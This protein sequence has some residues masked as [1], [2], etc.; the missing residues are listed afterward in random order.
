MKTLQSCLFFFLT[1]AASATFALDGWRISNK[2]NLRVYLPTDL[3]KEQIFMYV[4]SGPYDLN[5]AT[6]KGWFSRKAR[7]MQNRLGKPLKAWVV[8]PDKGNWS[9]SNQYQDK[10]G[11]Q[12]S[13]G[14]Q[15][16][17]LGNGR[18]YIITMISSRDYVLIM[19]YGA[20]YEQVLND[21]KLYLAVKPSLSKISATAAKTEKIT[22]TNRKTTTKKGKKISDMVRTAPGK[23]A[24]LDDIELVWVTSGIDVLWGGIDV[25]THLLFEDGTAYKD[26]TI[27]PDELDVVASKRLEPHK[28]TRWR[29]HWGTYQ[30]KNEKKDLWYDLK[31][32]PGVKAPKGT[33]LNGKF[34][35]AGGSQ[36]RGAW[37]RRI[38]FHDDGRFEL[39]SFSIQGNANMGG[40]DTAPLVTAVHSSDKH[41]SSGA[42][43]VI[44]THV[45]GGTSG[46][47][48]DGSKNT[49]TYKVNNYTI[50]MEHD[51]GWKHTEL[52]FIEKRKDKKNLVY[53]NALYW[54]DD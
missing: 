33:G 43:S 9:I 37:K 29:K 11:T 30:M 6:L 17:M 19:K 23:G 32:G 31:G 36:Y 16:G 53:G 24:D 22:P 34:L 50:V 28:W 7:L 14:Y 25:D 41:G 4:A 38:I 42:T 46:K 45:G 20:A 54:L 8:K 52:F 1:F 5:G 47:R 3:Q 18:A 12:L 35:T 2:E 26:C 10:N 49:G 21:A 51:N 44:G 39:S 27:P 15:G 40:G 48:K 13:V